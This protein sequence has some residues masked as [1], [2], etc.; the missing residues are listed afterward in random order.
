MKFSYTII[1]ASIF[2]AVSAS[3]IAK[4]TASSMKAI[5]DD[6]THLAHLYEDTVTALNNFPESG[7]QGATVCAQIL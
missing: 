6:F 1:A 7:E 3:T 4:S 5:L 2:A